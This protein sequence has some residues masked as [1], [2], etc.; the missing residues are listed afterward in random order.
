[1][2]MDSIFE[3]SYGP[4]EL[5]GKEWEAQPFGGGGGHVGVWPGWGGYRWSRF[6]RKVFL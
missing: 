6:Y 4:V 3:F 5:S 2:G 1:M